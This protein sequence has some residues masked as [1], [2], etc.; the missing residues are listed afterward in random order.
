MGLWCAALPFVTVHRGSEPKPVTLIVPYYE[1][2]VFFG[3]Q[4][5]YWRSTYPPELRAHLSII[6]VDDGSQ[7]SPIK[8]HGDP[9]DVRSFRMFRISRDVRWNWLAARNIGFHHAADGWCLVTDI[10]HLVQTDALRACI[11]GAHDPSTVYAFSR[12]EHTGA[13]A[14]PHSASFFMTRAMF[15]TIGGYDETLSGHYGTDGEF[16]RR[17]AAVA[18]MAVMTEPLIRYEYVDDSSTTRYLRKQ[19][20]D[21][22]VKKLVAARKPGW[23]PKV[24]SFE[25][26]EVAC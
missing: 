3:R 26:S 2:P 13:A 5:W 10:D 20:Q 6:V 19:P 22:A 25:Y 4:L 8:M 7:T 23:R 14:H 11:Y 16:R 1:N 21:A 24:L 15:W 17:V 9:P 12:V 18:K